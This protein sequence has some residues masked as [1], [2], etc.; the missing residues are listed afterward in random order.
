MSAPGGAPEAG[1]ACVE[2]LRRSWLLAELGAVLD[3]SCRA[4]GRLLDLL[5]LDDCELIAALGGRR[6]AELTAAHQVFR[7]DRALRSDQGGEV[8]RH[9]KRYPLR[10]RATGTAS[11]LHLDGGAR[12]VERLRE[13]TAR[14]VVAFVG[15]G[16]SSDYGAAITASLARSLATSGV[17]I[18]GELTGAIGPA[19]LGGALEVEAGAIGAIAGGLTVGVPARRRSLCRRLARSGCAISELP[20]TA[21]CRRWCTVGCE[22]V[23]AS[24]ASVALVVEADDSPSG[25]SGARIAATLG[26]IVAAVPGR[27]T[28]RGS[29]GAHALLRDG[30]RLVTCAADV[31][32]LI[33]DADGRESIAP[34]QAPPHAGL[35][36]RLLRVL[37]R[38][39]AG[40]DTPGRLLAEADDAGELFRALGELELSGLLTRGDGGRYLAS[41]PLATGALRYGV[42]DQMEP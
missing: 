31:L 16:A 24:L 3:C 11:M 27:V 6:R 25:L 8:C 36:P 20:C 21:P 32:E 18:A 5:L 29:C 9:D 10:L 33:C 14:P 7:S 30:A 28:S 4:D 22:R 19:A 2:C 42:R 39:G 35:E 41:D 17:T 23:L 34:A 1:R 40:C 13:L 38:V 15:H 37:E 12:P 26:R